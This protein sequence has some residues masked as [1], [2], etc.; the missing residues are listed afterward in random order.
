MVSGGQDYSSD[1]TVIN[2]VTITGTV[3]ISGTVTISGTVS[4]TGTVT[5]TGSVSISGTVT[6]T[7]AVT[8][9]GSVT[10]SGTVSVSG[11][12]T[13]SGTVS[14]SGTVTVSGS[15]TVSGTVAV[16]GT[17]TV[18]GTV[19]ISG[20]VTVSGAVTVTGSV[21]VSG[22][23]A[24]SGTVTVDGAVTVTG[25]VTVSGTV[26]ISGTVTISGAVTITSGTVSISGTVTISGAV[27]VTS[28]SITV[29]GTVAISG[30]VTVT[31]SVSV[32]GSV[33][34]SGSVSI[35]GSVTVTGAVTITGSVS[36]TNATLNVTVGNTVLA[37]GQ[38]G[39]AVGLDGAAS[40]ISVAHHADLTVT[41]EDF[42]IVVKRRFQSLASDVRFFCK[43]SESVD[44]YDLWL[45]T[46]G[47]LYI[48][49]NVAGAYDWTSTSN[50]AI[51][52]DTDYVIHVTR[53][54]TVCKIYLNG[55]DK[56][57]YSASHRDPVTNTRTLYLDCYDTL[58]FKLAGIDYWSRFYKGKAFTATEVATDYVN[59]Q[60]PITGSLK[61]WLK[62]NEGSGTSAADSSGL[63]H[64]GTLTSC[65]WMSA[66]G[67]VGPSV[68]V[69]ISASQVT[70]NVSVT[71]TVSITGTVA[72]SGSVTITGTVAI[73][74]SV[75]VTGTVS[76]SGTVTITINAQNVDLTVLAPTG[77]MVSA[78]GIVASSG[79]IAMVGLSSNAETEVFVVTARGRLQAFGLYLEGTDNTDDLGRS[80]LRIYVDGAL[81]WYA[82]FEQIDIRYNG[83][84]LTT[85]MLVVDTEYAASL[86]NPVIGVLYCK[87]H[88]TVASD[89]NR[90]AM[91][92]NLPF[93]FTS[94][95]SIRIRTYTNDGGT[96]DGHVTYGVYV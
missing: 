27:T 63:A 76:I 53:S 32:T 65:V 93:E 72:I 44:G 88:H 47:R 36:I 37:T 71:N 10:V 78:G 43:G 40:Y 29:S 69:N 13:I 62:L 38:T 86:T 21:T 87:T 20:T 60:S 15:V 24:I 77:K 9:T 85:K 42:T 41:S 4:V 95:L 52:V 6:V 17:V 34:V 56:T 16:S 57:V 81:K 80:E 94:S 14:V 25:S 58:A 49:T 8:V 55:I 61:L 48:Q 92:C 2:T 79:D 12:V 70:L 67:A 5:V 18:S 83:R 68:A 66:Q 84:Q 64:T 19:A 91:F 22:T 59:P 30:T 1:V 31:G 54:G 28:G 11:T 35:T 96:C 75:T 7:G 90:L 23:V 89:M 45:N 50:D 33:T 74:G 46:N 26:S 82:T 39:P 3:V 73:S 51:V